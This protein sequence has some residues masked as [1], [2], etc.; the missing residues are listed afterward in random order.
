MP[1]IGNISAIFTSLQALK[2]LS[3]TFVDVRDESLIRAKVSEL[4]DH[5]LAAQEK[6]LE[7]QR[8]QAALLAELDATKKRLAEFE[9]WEREKKRYLLRDFGGGTFAWELK[10][11]EVTADEPQHLVCPNCFG[12]RK[13][14]ILQFEFTTSMGQRKF[15][16]LRCKAEL[17]LGVRRE[18]Y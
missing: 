9:D 14:S 7:A 4:T 8:M 16:C 10:D 17:F 2:E 3:K 13:K 18:S 12:E 1:D 15:N 5:I 6:T 11:E